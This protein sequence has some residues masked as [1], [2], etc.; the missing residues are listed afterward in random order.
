MRTASA[1]LGIKIQSC[2]AKVNIENLELMRWISKGVII[3][4]T[5]SEAPSVLLN[6]QIN[7]L[8]WYMKNDNNLELLDFYISPL[9]REEYQCCLIRL[10]QQDDSH[11]ISHP[12]LCI[13]PF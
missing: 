4:P 2:S 13:N 9:R 8:S 3:F 6:A 7:T 12:Q 5:Y 1:N 11:N 10:F